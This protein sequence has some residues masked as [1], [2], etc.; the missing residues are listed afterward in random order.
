[1]STLIGSVRES[2]SKGMLPAASH[3]RRY[4]KSSYAKHKR[5]HESYFEVSRLERR[6]V[7]RS[8]GV[9]VISEVIEC[10]RT[11]FSFPDLTHTAE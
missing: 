1:M 6:Q 8:S 11:I 9:A 4:L 2:S 5:I 7:L 3:H 10:E